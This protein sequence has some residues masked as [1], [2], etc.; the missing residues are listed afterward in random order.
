MP[1]KK[2]ILLIAQSVISKEIEAITH[3]QDRL[4][5]DF[6]RSIQMI[7]SSEGR[8]IVSGIGKSVTTFILY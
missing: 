7:L 6:T 5:D 2:K 3:L 4:T 1:N 8:L